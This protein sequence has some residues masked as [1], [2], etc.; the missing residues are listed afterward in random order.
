MKTSRISLFLDGNTVYAIINFSR[1]IQISPNSSK[2]TGLPVWLDE[3]VSRWPERRSCQAGHSARAERKLAPP[4]VHAARRDAACAVRQATPPAQPSERAV[5]PGL[6]ALAGNKIRLRIL[7]RRYGDSTT[8]RRPA[9]LRP[10][11]T[12]SVRRSIPHAHRQ[13]SKL[14]ATF[15]LQNCYLSTD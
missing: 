7:R 12:V 10:K 9:T 14:T 11:T 3:L 4:A 8:R 1:F 5:P 13:R 6:A 2:R 15:S